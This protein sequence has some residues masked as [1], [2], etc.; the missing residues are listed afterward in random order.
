MFLILPTLI[1]LRYHSHFPL[2][3]M[4]RLSLGK[5]SVLFGAGLRRRDLGSCLGLAERDV[6]SRVD[7]DLLRL[8]L[9]NRGLLVG[10]RLDHTRVTRDSRN[11][12]LAEELDVIRLVGEVL[13]GQRVDL[14]AA[15]GAVAL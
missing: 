4:H 3:H 7:L 1:Q 12:L 14:Q 9:P 6:S 2:D 11:A 15:G 10:R 5:W 13:D 8:G